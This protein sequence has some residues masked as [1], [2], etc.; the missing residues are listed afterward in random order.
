MICIRLIIM[1]VKKNSA[2]VSKRATNVQRVKCTLPLAK[3]GGVNTVPLAKLFQAPDFLKKRSIF[4]VFQVNEGRK[5]ATKV[6]LLA[7]IPKI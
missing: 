1:G 2:G 4:K 6:F 7:F 5:N 3:R